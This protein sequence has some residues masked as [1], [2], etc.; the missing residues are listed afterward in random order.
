MSPKRGE[1]V[2]P[3]AGADE[4]EV[5]FGNTTAA[6]GWENLCQQAPG[7]TCDAWHQMR[8]NPAPAPPTPRHHQLK[9]ALAFAEHGGKHLA[10]WQIEVTGGGRIWYLLDPDRR[11]IWVTEAGTGHPKKTD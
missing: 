10:C 2:A 4:W 11:T 5:R 6:K 8:T 7:N 9:G 3:P 1:R